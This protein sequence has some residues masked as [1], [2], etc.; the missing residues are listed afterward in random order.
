MERN[1]IYLFMITK[2]QEL[3]KKMQKYENETK[4]AATN[5]ISVS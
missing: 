2:F 4:T 5:E 1:K 3:R